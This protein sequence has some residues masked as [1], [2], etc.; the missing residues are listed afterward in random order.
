[1]LGESV[2]AA[3]VAIQ[4]ALSSGEVLAALAPMILGG[5]LI[6]YS[7]WWVYFDRPVHDLL[8]SLPKA[9]LWGYGH[10]LVFAAAAAVG[11]GLAV[12]VD[13]VTHRAHVGA[14]TAGA[15]VAVPVAVYL[16]CLWF[17]H[18]RPDYRRGTRLAGPIAAG[19][20]LLTPLTPQPVLLSGVVLAGM[21]IVK[22]AL[23]RPHA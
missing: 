22:L 13:Q 20:V 3:N 10:Y 11:A 19:L 8:T 6:V 12:T 4:S 15:A 14:V 21:V 18:N 16:L 23:L 7:M 1:M 5:L 2:L 9:I 17:L